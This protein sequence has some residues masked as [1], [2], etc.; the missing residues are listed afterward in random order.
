M[1]H[2]LEF[3]NQWW[4]VCRDCWHRIL[5]NEYDTSPLKLE[6]R[7]CNYLSIYKIS[8]CPD[9]NPTY[10][11][12]PRENDIRYCIT[13]Y[14]YFN[15]ERKLMATSINKQSL[16]FIFPLQQWFQSTEYDI[17]K[18]E[19]INM[20]YRLHWNLYKTS[21]NWFIPC[22]SFRLVSNSCQRWY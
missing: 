7:I 3:M 2:K 19:K 15:S 10:F 18:K 11:V 4:I 20:K 14:Y 21:R 12:W 22:I 9:L 17:N 13:M 8:I 16:I 1:V 6:P 5:N